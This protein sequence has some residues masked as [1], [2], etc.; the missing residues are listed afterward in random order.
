[1]ERIKNLVSQVAI[2]NKK[3]MEILD[4]TGGRFNMFKICGVNHYENTHSAI[5]AEFL[6]PNGT[7]GLKNKLL[8]CF[9]ET[10][11][12]KMGSFDFNSEKAQVHTEYTT[13]EGRIDILLEDNQNRAIIIENKVYAGDQP[14]QLKRYN[15]YAEK[16]KND[17]QILYLTLMG[18]EASEQSGGG[19]NY[20]PISY[21]E[22]VIN[23]LENCVAIASR[24]PI[25]RETI[26]QY[27]NHL[28]QLTNQDMYTKN[29]EEITEFLSNIDNLRAAKAISQNY[30]A[31]FDFLME[32]HF[33]PKME[34]FAEQKGLEYQF[35]GSDE[36]NVHFSLIH[37]T[38]GNKYWIGFTYENDGKGCYYGICNN[39]DINF[40]V[41][42]KNRSE[43]HA[44]LHDMGVFGGRE[45][46]YWP[47]YVYYPNLSL[48]VWENDIVKSDNFV[49]DCM[50]KIEKLLKVM[51]IIEL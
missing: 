1:M 45:S 6:N 41:S 37:P 47:F 38:W 17:Y 44:K 13:E 28:K 51:D 20:I 11:S 36:W 10:L 34:K 39:I 50:N 24:F 29:Q 25:V 7:H 9:K 27:I 3:N 2:I 32:K 46:M 4:A 8:K 43:I 21:K 18:D 23:W 30:A 42:E 19:V 40:K 26:V 14:E 48:N 31:T 12:D 16:Y 22:H 5:I 49:N 35:Y 15:R 33:N